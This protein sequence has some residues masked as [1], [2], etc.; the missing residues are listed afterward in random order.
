M[1]FLQ[2]DH[3]LKSGMS[4]IKNHKKLAPLFIGFGN[5]AVEYANVLKYF[6]INIKSA[7][8]TSL[9][10]NKEKL[11]KFKIKYR[12]NNIKI[13]LKEKKYNSVFV[14]L[15]WNIIE[16][17]IIY[18]IKNTKKNIYCEKP[19]A[20]SL[21]KLKKISAVS[22]KYNNNLYILYNRRYYKNYSIIEKKINKNTKFEA[23]IPEKIN[24]TLKKID[25][26]LKGKV[27]Y[28]LTSHWLD[29][30]LTL[31][32]QNFL[33][34]SKK[35]NLFIFENK[36]LENKIIIHPNGKGYIKANFKSKNFLLKLN[37]L[38]KLT[39]K[40]IKNNKIINYFNEHNQ[41]KFKPGVH[42]L[43]KNILYK[44]KNKLPKPKD[45]L[46]LYT[47]LKDLPF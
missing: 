44:K 45:L 3:L 21:K 27:K 31:T 41:N 29:F 5:Q 13:A 12:Y 24:S 43:L 20:L 38:E 2:E 42:N 37:S 25:K 11:N 40:N 18:I 22:K 19:I 46:T 17:K 34:L 36:K 39:I 9:K 7:C 4:I 33:K 26:R 30:F 1:V 32:K 35:K 10:K 15:P 16:K 47:Y 8:V 14:F 23:Y 28:H 6:N